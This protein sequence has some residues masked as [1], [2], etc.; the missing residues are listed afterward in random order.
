MNDKLAR[1]KCVYDCNKLYLELKD[2]KTEKVEVEEKIDI[3]LK[4]SENNRAEIEKIGHALYEH[5]SLAVKNSIQKN[6]INDNSIS[7]TENAL[8]KYINDKKDNE[9]II[10][11][12]S[13]ETGSL[14]NS[15][16]S[17]NDAEET[18]NT[19]FH[20][21]IKRKRELLRSERKSLTR[22]NKRRATD[23]QGYIRKRMSSILR[24]KC[25]PRK[26]LILQEN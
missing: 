13:T 20:C 14:Q 10:R 5:Y 24:Q 15:V 12:K 8:N 23:F 1:Q 4:D 11:Q 2:I 21:D 3:L 16:D 19:S 17:Y 6:E 9:K 25:F 22:K 18:F 7:D 26:K